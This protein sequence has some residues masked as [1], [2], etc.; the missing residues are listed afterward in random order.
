MKTCLVVLFTL[1]STSILAQSSP[2]RKYKFFKGEKT[3]IKK[4]F[5]LRDPFVKKN[6]TII[7]T[8]QIKKKYGTSF[9][10]RG[11]LNF[12]KLENMRHVGIFL[13]KNR[14]AL[15]KTVAGVDRD[16]GEVK[17]AKE[18]YILKEGMRLGE[19]RAEI[20]AILPGG[21]VLVE[22]IKNV[23]EQDEIL[24]TILPLHSSN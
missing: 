17:F 13:V 2:G 16:T 21:V 9:T 6:R 11:Q 5:Q 10:N 4:P 12:I 15:A 20:K 14:K 22:R 8:T 23:Y 7:S 19:N 1:L 3:N 24:E 18:V